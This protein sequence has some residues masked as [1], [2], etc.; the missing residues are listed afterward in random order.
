M[1]CQKGAMTVAKFKV[2]D[3]GDK[4][5]SGK[6]CR[7]GPPGGLHRLAGQYDNPMPE[8]TIYQLPF[9]DYEFGYWIYRRMNNFKEAFMLMSSFLNCS[10][11]QQSVYGI[12]HLA[13]RISNLF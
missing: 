9:R 4:V 11:H 1:I 12:Y 13:S 6:G 2:H 10:T 5:D 8:S 3:W 7:T